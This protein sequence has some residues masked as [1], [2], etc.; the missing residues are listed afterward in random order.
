MNDDDRWYEMED[1]INMLD[2]AGFKY[3]VDQG[4]KFMYRGS[5]NKTHRLIDDVT[6]V[7]VF[8]H[9]YDDLYVVFKNGALIDMS[10]HVMAG[11]PGTDKAKEWWEKS[12]DEVW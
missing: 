5:T 11:F 10:S 4:A 12:S 2:A 7:T 1:Y 3:T 6:I 8:G 9:F